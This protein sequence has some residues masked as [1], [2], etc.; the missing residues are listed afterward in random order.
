M[1]DAPHPAPPMNGHRPP[2]EAAAVP[3]EPAIEAV[4]EVVP[5]GDGQAMTLPPALPASPDDADVLKR[6][7]APFQLGT[8]G[9]DALPET[10][11]MLRAPKAKVSRLWVLWRLAS[12]LVL[13]LFL[14][15]SKWQGSGLCH[16]PRGRADPG[17]E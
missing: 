3:P 17:A 9:R 15:L 16:A 8:K 14:V 4:L 7:P 2:A 11:T 12:M 1:P 5:G 13:G 6:L 10:S